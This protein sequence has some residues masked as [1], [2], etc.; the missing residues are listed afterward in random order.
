MH[1]HGN[2]RIS[3]LTKASSPGRCW[4]WVL[5]DSH[6]IN[7]HFLI[8]DPINPIR[9]SSALQHRSGS[10]Q[11]CF[12]E[13]VQCV[14]TRG[15]LLKNRGSTTKSTS[16]WFKIQDPSNSGICMLFLGRGGPCTMVNH[17]YL[18]GG[19]KEFLFLPL[20]LEKWSNFWLYNIFQLGGSTTNKLL[21]QVVKHY[22]HEISWSDVF[23]PY[24]IE[25]SLKIDGEVLKTRACRLIS[26]PGRGLRAKPQCWEEKL[27]Q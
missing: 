7:H 5:L 18:A 27:C 8:K 15:D 16:W 2:L 25:V 4:Y 19:F 11:A 9:A 6:D 12:G 20:F 17:I 10:P 24:I 14:A 26:S 13:S 21:F 3:K 1:D 22:I 23:F